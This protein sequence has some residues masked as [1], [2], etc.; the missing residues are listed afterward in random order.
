LF[1]VEFHI[2]DDKTVFFSEPYMK[3]E[4]IHLFYVVSVVYFSI[5]SINFF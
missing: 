1:N 4:N 5:T 3:N 2:A